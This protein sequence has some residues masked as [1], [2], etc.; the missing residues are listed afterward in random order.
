MNAAAAPNSPTDVLWH[1]T[2][3]RDCHAC[4]RPPVAQQLSRPWTAAGGGLVHDLFLRLRHPRRQH[5]HDLC[6]HRLRL[7]APWR[8]CWKV[9]RRMSTESTLVVKPRRSPQPSVNT[10]QIPNC[11]PVFWVPFWKSLRALLNLTCQ[12]T[13][14]AGVVWSALVW[15][16]VPTRPWL[17]ARPTQMEPH[18]NVRQLSSR[19]G[20]R[21]QVH[22]CLKLTQGQQR[23]RHALTVEG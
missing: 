8:H 14:Q 5:V 23:R 18:C 1:R 16:P 10:K 6:R 9:S 19:A 3:P 21:G 20:V 11:W 4:R 17:E 12:I 22:R 15:P 7:S 2:A 13:G